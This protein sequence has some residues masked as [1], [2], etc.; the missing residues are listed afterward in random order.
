MVGQNAW[1]PDIFP[2]SGLGHQYQNR[3]NY[4]I[5]VTAINDLGNTTMEY[6]VSAQAP[7]TSDFSL[8]VTPRETLFVAPGG[9]CICVFYYILRHNIIKTIL[10]FCIILQWM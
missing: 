5:L 6:V 9:T 4:T 2:T 1:D 8:T 10:K 7:V 3:G